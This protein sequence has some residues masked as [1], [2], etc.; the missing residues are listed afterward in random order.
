MMADVALGDFES[1]PG[2]GFRIRDVPESG[3]VI[4]RLCVSLQRQQLRHRIRDGS[5]NF[6]ALA[7]TNV[8]R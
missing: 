8:P 3:D 1:T 6:A 7:H 4:G 2:S 5:A